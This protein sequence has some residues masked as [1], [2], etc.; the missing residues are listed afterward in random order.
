M[1]SKTKIVV[2]HMK[3]IIYTGIF[4]L[5]LVILGILMFFMFEPGKTMTAST[6]AADLYIPG[7]YRTSVDLNGNTFDVEVTVDSDRIQ[8][9]RLNNLSETTAAMFPLVEPALDSL[10]S[11]IYSSQSLENLDYSSDQKY[12]SM[13][14]IDAIESALEKAR[15]E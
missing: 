12:T 1:S 11:Q 2:L 13:M 6:D 14:L 5:F 15:T 7:V 8:S 4:L 9:I 3:E 10:A